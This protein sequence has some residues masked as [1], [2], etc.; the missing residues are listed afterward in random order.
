MCRTES[1]GNVRAFLRL[2]STRQHSP[3][4][5]GKQLCVSV[6]EYR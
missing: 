4:P 3:A 1:P 6:D 2:A 5:I